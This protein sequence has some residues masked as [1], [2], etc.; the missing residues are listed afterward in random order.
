METGTD[1]VL[2]SPYPRA[3]L[4]CK[5]PTPARAVAGIMAAV[6]TSPRVARALEAVAK[7]TAPLGVPT[8]GAAV[9]RQGTSVLVELPAAG[10]I[11]RV[12]D[13]AP[14]ERS[15][16]QVRA[17]QVLASAGVPSI[18][19]AF[20]D[21]QPIEALVERRVVS[22][23]LWQREAHVGRRAEPAEVGR[24]AR[25]LHDATAGG[26][27][28]EG[29]R[30]LL[31]LQA[32]GEQIEIARH[33]RA[34]PGDDLDVLAAAHDRLAREWAAAVEDAATALVHG[35]LHADN[36][37]V[38]PDGPRLCD[39]ELAGVGPTAYDLVPQVVAVERYG[40][41]A[42]DLVAFES[43]YGAEL[44]ALARS[45]PLVEV[46]ELWV[47]AWA[48]ANRGIDDLH[49]AEAERRLARWRPD[50][51]HADHEPWTLR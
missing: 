44:P 32:V 19:L 6:T 3:V 36:V 7:A 27:G 51:Q 37:I 4:I 8:D 15:D 40:A 29:L 24:L 33:D 1:L 47:A 9:W 39:L 2:S 22:V 23:T 35:D 49:E 12:D 45:G 13:V 43:A 31:P 34:S 26:A 30:P 17:A 50:P 16:R 41:P 38:T 10:V 28:C 20:T 11:A 5:Q 46:Y 21:E 18:R 14:P 48:V 25:A 42:T